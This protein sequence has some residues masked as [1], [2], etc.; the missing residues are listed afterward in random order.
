[1]TTFYFIVWIAVLTATAI[2]FTIK[3]HYRLKPKEFRP[4]IHLEYWNT[5]SILLL[6]MINDYRAFNDLVRLIPEELNHTM[7]DVRCTTVISNFFI[8]GREL[9]HKG[10]PDIAGMML[11]EGIIGMG[12]NLAYGYDKNILAFRH[13]TE[14]ESHNEN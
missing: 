1:M 2:Y 10:F 6:G 13:F 12:E 5:D 8:E 7:A 14:S 9:S 4:V 11:K 3:Y